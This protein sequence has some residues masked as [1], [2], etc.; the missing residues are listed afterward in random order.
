MMLDE[1]Y[2]LFFL[3]VFGFNIIFDVLV[4]FIG[5]N[6]FYKKVYF[7]WVIYEGV[8]FSY[9]YYIECLC[10]INLKL[11]YIICIVGGVMNFLVWLQ[12]F[13]DIF[14]VMLEIV[15]VKE[16]GI[17]GIVMIVVVM[18]GWF[19][20]VFV[21]LN[22]MVYVLC[23]VFFNLENYWVYQIKYQFYKNLLLEMQLLWKS[24]SNYIV[25]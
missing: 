14:Q 4:G 9:F 1:S 6:S 23:I 17:L 19:V 18:V 11:S 5:V 8:V 15:D 16:Y 12:I 7:L 13:V 24:C 3:F 22:D 21:V 25:Y 20:E 2:L 10:N